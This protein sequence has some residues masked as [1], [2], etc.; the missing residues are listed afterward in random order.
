MWIKEPEGA[1]AC[2]IEGRRLRREKEEERRELDTE[3]RRCGDLG[4]GEP[5]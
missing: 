4:T 1:L 2:E 5:G 3:G